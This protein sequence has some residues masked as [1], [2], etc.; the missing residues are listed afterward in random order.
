[1]RLTIRARQLR[2]GDLL[3]STRTVDDVRPNPYNARQVVIYLREDDGRY[4]IW[5]AST[6]VTVE[7]SVREV[8]ADARCP[9]GYSWFRVDVDGTVELWRS[10]W[11]SSG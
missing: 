2:A 6:T 9:W 10:N 1:M 5:N 3:V 11:D 8:D 4:R 7:R